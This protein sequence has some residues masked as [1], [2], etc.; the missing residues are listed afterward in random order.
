MTGS[1]AS[2]KPSSLANMTSTTMLG[3]DCRNDTIVLNQN[4]SNP[5]LTISLSA[6]NGSCNVVTGSGSGIRVLRHNTM[7]F[8]NAQFESNRGGCVMWPSAH[9]GDDRL[10]CLAFVNNTASG[11]GGAG[12]S[13]FCAG[14]SYNLTNC[15]FFRNS[16]CVLG[17]V[18]AASPVVAF[19]NCIFDGEPS[20]TGANASVTFLSSVILA[21]GDEPPPVC[22]W[23]SVTTQL[24]TLDSNEKGDTFV[25]SLW[26]YVA[27]G[28]GGAVV[29]I[30][31]VVIIVVCCRSGSDSSEWST[32]KAGTD[33]KGLEETAA[34]CIPVDSLETRMTD[35]QTEVTVD[36]LESV[37]QATVDFVAEFL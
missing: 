37:S 1:F 32:Q 12:G 9:S 3:G 35:Q 17:I 20:T 27:V 31:I 10:D 18:D 13:I 28:G 23:P 15:V 4:D 14:A 8:V 6:I 25:G 7:T 21:S 34:D 33:E 19:L 22:P 26:F 11:S 24:F 2:L 5:N 30:V 29:I 36:G 16:G